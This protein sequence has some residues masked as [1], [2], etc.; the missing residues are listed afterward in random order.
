[1]TKKWNELKRRL[2]KERGALCERC[3]LRPAADLHH[4]LIGRMKGH[5]ELDVKENGEL[6]CKECHAN[7][8][9]Y[10][11]KKR[12]WAKQC[13]RYGEEHMEKW[14]DSLDLKVKPRF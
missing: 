6:L 2:I 11:Q 3:R 10:E 1:L 7:A 9:G 12:F 14:L 13:A 8:G 4:A 5:P